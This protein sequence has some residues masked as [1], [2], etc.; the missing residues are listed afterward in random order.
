MKKIVSLILVFTM[1]F[2]LTIT[3][4]VSA[5]NIETEKVSADIGTYKDINGD[6][7]TIEK[8]ETSNVRASGDS[9]ANEALA[10]EI[11][12]NGVYEET[13]I[14]DFYND[15]ITHEYADGKIKDDVLSDVV[16]ITP[17]TPSADEEAD[18]RSVLE[19]EITP[20]SVD[21]VNSEHFDILPNGD[22]AILTG[23]VVYDGYRA[24]GNRGGYYYAPDLF[25]YLQR[26]NSGIIRYDYSNRF[27]FSA[28]TTISTAVAIIVA[29]VTGSGWSILA[30]IVSELISPLVDTITYDYDLNFEKRTYKWSYRVRLNSN[31]GSIIYTT[32]RT[33]DYW[34]AHR[35]DNG[36]ATFEYAGSRYDDGFMLANTELIKAAI[37]SYIEANLK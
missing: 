15:R 5:T 1:L 7:M 6:I 18:E 4:N 2:S 36:N 26:Q 17:I 32:Y 28:G 23:G 14:V 16:T 11:T 30:D 35:P 21:Y 37:D 3:S 34:K 12:R 9:N 25:G 33:K 13:I 20:L 10:F 27:G 31:T 22:Q 8:I 19:G 29:A 24:M